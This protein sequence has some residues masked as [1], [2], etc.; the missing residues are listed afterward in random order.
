MNGVPVSPVFELRDFSVDL[1]TPTG[2]VRLA[3]EISLSVQQGETLCVVG[4][5]GSGKSVTMLSAL[6]LFEYSA[7]VALTGSVTIDGVEVLDLSQEQM[8]RI[9]AQST[10]V[11]FQEAMEAL[12]PTRKI[13]YQ[14]VEAYLETIESAAVT[15]RGLRRIPTA[16]REEAHRKALEL[17][18][19]VGLVDPP[20]V[21]DSYPHQLSGGMQQRVIIAMALMGDPKLLIADEPTTA[22]DVTV[23]ADILRLLRRLQ[24]DRKMSCVLITHDMGVASEVADRIAVL[25]AGQVVEVGPLQQ[26]LESP[27]HPYTKALLECVPRPGVR[28]EGQMRTIPGSVPAPGTVFVGD[29]FAPRN[30]LASEQALTE[31]PPV[32]IS[33]DGTHMVRSW[34][35]V[36]S[37][38]TELVDTLTGTT[39]DAIATRPAPSTTDAIVSLRNLNKT[40]ASKARATR[41]AAAASGTRAVKDLDLDI[42]RGEIFGIVGET[43]SGKSTLGRLITDL[44]SADLDSSIIVDGINFKAKRTFA[45]ERELRGKVQ[46]IFQNPQDTLDPRRTI[47]QAIAEPLFAL[48]D[49]SRTQVHARVLEMLDAVRLPAATASKY[50]SEISGGQRQR[51]AVARALSSRP[52]LIVADEPTSALDVS[53]QGQIINL[54]LDLQADFSLT[55][56]FITHNLSLITAIA[57]RVGVMYHGELVEVG[58][59]V[60]LMAAPKHDYTA[61][62]LASNPDPFA[63]VQR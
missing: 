29:R 25:Y 26:M 13:S 42:Y 38:T 15:T 3:D 61:R 17:L 16:V 57:D 27:Q 6:R 41:V 9:R 40:Y 21:M 20:R 11:V 44:E 47:E 32:H 63:K 62:L 55:Y 50:A 52:S 60:D 37:W 5:S 49:L 33:A 19:E 12:N 31:I 36:L 8:S 51:V 22:L 18:D 14:L 34:D 53:V 30:A 28:L 46:M 59:A 23:Q 39:A 54:L 7:P 48:T 10:G 58:S 1:I 24:A 45:K 56:V 43:G 4:E 2:K 35:P